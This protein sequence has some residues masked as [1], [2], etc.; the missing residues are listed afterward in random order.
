MLAPRTPQ[1]REELRLAGA[2]AAV[3][4][5]S[6][7]RRFSH[8]DARFYAPEPA[9]EGDDAE[10]DAEAPEVVRLLVEVRLT[11][12]SVGGRKAAS[13][14]RTA[15]QAVIDRRIH[16][17]VVVQHAAGEPPKVSGATVSL[18]L[19]RPDAR[20][21]APDDDHYDAEVLEIVRLLVEVRLTKHSVGGRKAA[22]RARSVVQEAIDCSI[23]K[24]IIAQHAAGEPPKVS[25]A[26]VSLA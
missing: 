26:T 1:L 14:V 11:K 15:V 23:H 5:P 13:V 25:G 8:P 24:H 16:E 9:P 4:D 10:Y 12:H 22:A 19:E 21:Y 20:F 18:A 17:H 3:P 2:G 6:K 7:T